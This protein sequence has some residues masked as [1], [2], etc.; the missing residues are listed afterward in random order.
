MKNKILKQEV[1]Q[2]IVTYME[3]D[4]SFTAL[5]ICN[6]LRSSYPNE[7]IRMKRVSEC[8]R[9]SALNISVRGGYEYEVSFIDIDSAMAQTTYLYHHKSFDIGD[10]LSRDQITLKTI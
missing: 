3:S 7:D 9:K 10:Y 2:A 5:D 6:Y 1:N 8:V 4:I